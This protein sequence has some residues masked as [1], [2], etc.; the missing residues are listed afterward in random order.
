M[1][2]RRHAAILWKNAALAFLLCAVPAWSARGQDT[3]GSAPDSD[4]LARGMT[5]ELLKNTR[6][7]KWDGDKPVGWS[8]W[9]PAKGSSVKRGPEGPDGGPTVELVPG[10]GGN[11]DFGAEVSD[12]ETVFQNGDCLLLE[13][14]LKVDEGVPMELLVTMTH[15]PNAKEKTPKALP[16]TGDG[17]WNT[18]RLTLP[19]IPKDLAKIGL[20]IRVR[21]AAKGTAYISSASL[22]LSSQV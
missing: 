19:E 8:F 22:I 2:N 20:S 14:T 15:G 6:F 7:E 11:V 16:F 4:T 10:E 9:N 18:L 12:K 17:N 21:G 5:G 3:S 1:G 13:V